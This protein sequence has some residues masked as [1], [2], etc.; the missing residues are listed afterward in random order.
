MILLDGINELG[1]GKFTVGVD[2][3]VEMATK[4]IFG[5]GFF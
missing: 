5:N 1:N 2:Q 4:T 3:L